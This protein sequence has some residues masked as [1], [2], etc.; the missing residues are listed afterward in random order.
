MKQLTHIMSLLTA[1]LLVFGVTAGPVPAHAAPADATITITNQIGDTTGD[2]VEGATYTITKTATVD[3]ATGAQT[4][5]ADG[6]SQTYTVGTT[7][8]LPVDQ[9][10]VYSI[11][12]T[13]RPD[14]YLLDPAEYTAEFPI[15]DGGA[16]SADQSLE[17]NPKITQ[18]TGDATLTKYADETTTVVPGAVFNL[19]RV[20]SKVGD[21]IGVVG[22]PLT[23]NESGQIVASGLTEGS[24]YFIETSVPEPY[25]AD[26]TTQHTFDVTSNAEGTQAQT[27][28]VDVQNYTAPQTGGET[29][30]PSSIT[31]TVDRDQASVGDKVTYTIAMVMPVDINQYASYVLTDSVP[32]GLSDVTATVDSTAFSV[33]TNGNDVTV[34]GTPGG[35]TGGQTVLVTIAG[36]VNNTVEPGESLENTAQVA[37]NNARGATGTTPSTMATV[38]IV[39]GSITVNKVTSS[40]EPLAGATFILTDS[41]TS[42]T[43]VNGADGQALQGVTNAEGK[44]VFN[45]LP[46][47]TYYL[48]EIDAPEGYRLP[49]TSLALTVD[50]TTTNIVTE[51]IVNY[52]TTES[53]P[54]TGT[55]GALPYYAVGTLLMGLFIFLMARRRREEKNPQ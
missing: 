22:E 2:F 34:T 6:A 24:Y 10:S 21:P 40:N 45:A 55:A 25:A 11:Q 16:V 41:P 33:S 5:I 47:G 48:R 53:L 7:G 31:K 12:M 27:V 49:D 18:L 20:S 29:A 52:L 23:T 50:G 43:P 35:L 42:T 15:L 8:A 17:I 54:Q 4:P 26:I 32:A 14:G 19:V 3:P 13:E 9:Y 39:A 46:Y 44:I 1:A 30:G 51:P 37:W 36:T 38:A 28:S